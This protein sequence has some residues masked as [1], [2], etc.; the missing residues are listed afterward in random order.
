[1]FAG[2]PVGWFAPEYKFLLEVWDGLTKALKPLISRSNQNERRIELK[3][4]G[5]LE[6]WSLEGGNAG[7]SRKYRRVIID[8]AAMVPGLM[9]RWTEDIRPTLTDLKGDAWM[10]S[11][12]K[13][14]NDFY[15]LW[16][17]GQ[18]PLDKQWKSWQMPTTSNP[19]IDPLEVED[20]RKDMPERS[21][22]QEYL[23]EFLEDSAVFRKISDAATAKRQRYANDDID[24]EPRHNYVIGVD[25]GKVEDYSVFTVIDTTVKELCYLDRSNGI[26]YLDQLK[27]LARLH[28]A[29]GASEI[30]VETNSQATT[31]ELLRQSGLP[32]REFTTS[33]ESKPY[34]IE[35]LMLAFERGDLKIIPDPVLLSEL[36]SFEAQRLPSGYV[37]Y[38]APKGYH[39]DCVMSLALAWDAVKD[40]LQ[41][42]I[43]VYKKKKRWR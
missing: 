20:A 14:R 26:D 41:S 1:M 37:R 30:V 22:W 36:R 23:A 31:I 10:L 17:R 28:A 11:T 18:D 24:P 19:F 6:M 43:R 38:T 40:E 4:G 25:W 29:F 21:F 12:P 42:P 27:R 2:Y 35:N 39:D 16:A 13:G 34:V 8:E 5:T 9:K 33:K 15:E 7:R 32:V 3:N